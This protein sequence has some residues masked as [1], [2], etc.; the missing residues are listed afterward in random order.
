[1]RLRTQKAPLYRIYGS[2]G[3]LHVESP[4]VCHVISTQVLTQKYSAMVLIAYFTNDQIFV[5]L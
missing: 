4:E 2:I 3:L 1:M 5:P